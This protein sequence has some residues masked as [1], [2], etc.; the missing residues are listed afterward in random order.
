MGRQYTGSGGGRGTWGE[1]GERLQQRTGQS[2]V[3]NL[4]QRGRQ[5]GD[6]S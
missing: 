2:G 3:Q 6:V 5:D 4:E 1:E